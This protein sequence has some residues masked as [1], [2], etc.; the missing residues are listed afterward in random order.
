M[1]LELTCEGLLVKLANHYTTRAPMVESGK[2][3]GSNRFLK[4]SYSIVLCA[5]HKKKC[6][7]ERCLTPIH[8]IT[9][10]RLTCL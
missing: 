1:R 6:K 2:Y 4:Y 9:Q 8:K 7:Y 3:Y 5:P 10:G